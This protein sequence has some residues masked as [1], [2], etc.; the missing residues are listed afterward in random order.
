M[1]SSLPIILALLLAG[2]SVDGAALVRVI[3]TVPTRTE[4]QATA[5]ASPELKAYCVTVAFGVDRVGLQYYPDQGSVQTTAAAAFLWTEN[6]NPSYTTEGTASNGGAWTHA[7]PPLRQYHTPDSLVTLQDRITAYKSTQ[8]TGLQAGGAATT[9]YA[10]NWD[11]YSQDLL[12]MDGISGYL[13]FAAGSYRFQP[14]AVFGGATADAQF[15]NPSRPY[16]AGLKT[17]IFE[18]N[19]VY[20]LVITGDGKWSVTQPTTAAGADFVIN[21]IEE[22]TA[23]T[24]FGKA[25]LRWFHAVKTVRTETLS[26][27]N[28]DTSTAAV[29]ASA[30]PFGGVSN[31]V[32]ITP[33][34]AAVYPIVSSSGPTPIAPSSSNKYEVT[35]DVRAGLRATLICAVHAEAD[36]RVFC[37]MIPS[38]VVAYVRLVNDLA[39]FTSFGQG[40]GGALAYNRVK[41]DLFA[42][43]EL[44]RP[45]QAHESSQTGGTRAVLNHP[46][47]IRGFY[48][49]LSGVAPGACSGYSEVFVPVAIMDFAVRWTVVRDHIAAIGGVVANADATSGINLQNTALPTLSATQTA[50]TQWWFLGGARQKKVNI[51]IRTESG[52]TLSGSVGALGKTPFRNYV[53]TLE[54][55]NQ[56]AVSSDV[57]VEAGSF[58]SFAVT[59]TAGAVLAQSNPP[60]NA[61]AVLAHLDRTVEDVSTGVP[62]G[63]AFLTVGTIRSAKVMDTTTSTTAANAQSFGGMTIN[64]KPKSGSASTTY[65]FAA[66]AANTDAKGQFTDLAVREL[67]ASLTAENNQ[68]DPSYVQYHFSLAA[69]AY[70]LDNSASSTCYNTIPATDI[71]LASGDFVYAYVMNVYGCVNNNNDQTKLTTLFCSQ[72]AAAATGNDA[73]TLLN[74]STSTTTPG[75]SPQFF[76]AAAPAVSM[77]VSMIVATLFAVVAALL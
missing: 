7:M 68:W 36:S 71:T 50:G 42:S 48:K 5:S 34:V 49:V 37:R 45:D 6:M 47:N 64:M 57:F 77:S 59:P 13:S 27:Y 72:Q 15:S 14:Y 54:W 19:K 38:R 75:A 18:D 39:G 43:S 21:V 4:V 44:P 32:D 63:K 58:Y 55:V 20:T 29:I 41:L 76:F 12:K 31:Y 61:I 67:T 46:L 24:T 28:G 66:F 17:V 62:T 16:S 73:N 8:M 10:A 1:R 3:N 40:A 9:V 30:I 11:L 60:A 25:A 2:S 26:V 22:S 70:T 33:N 51:L 74:P 69:G 53:A 52:A 56:G 65:T 35:H 23:S